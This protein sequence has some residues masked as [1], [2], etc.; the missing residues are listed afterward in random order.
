MKTEKVKGENAVNPE[1]K[2]MLENLKKKALEIGKVVKD[3][4]LVGMQMGKHKAKELDL[5]RQKLT[6]LLAVGKRVVLLY[7]KGKLQTDELNALCE[8]IVKVDKDIA[9]QK[10]AFTQEKKKL[11]KIP[12]K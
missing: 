9:R 7:K 12:L 10:T 8:Q 4:A 2:E 11:K 6:K 3:D 5:E 1:V